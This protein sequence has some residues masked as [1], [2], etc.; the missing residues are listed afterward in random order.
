MCRALEGEMKGWRRPPSCPP[1]RPLPSPPPLPV[2]LLS[3]RLSPP[4]PPSHWSALWGPER[5]PRLSLRAGA[6]RARAP[7]SPAPLLPP[8]PCAP[9]RP[10]PFAERHGLRASP[11]LEQ[12]LLSVLFLKRAAAPGSDPRRDRGLASASR[13]CGP[14]LHGSGRVLLDLGRGV[15]GDESPASGR[16]RLPGNGGRSASP[17]PGSRSAPGSPARRPEAPG[18]DRA[19]PPRAGPASRVALH[20]PPAPA[21]LSLILPVLGKAACLLVR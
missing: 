13:G 4:S 20:P 12:A 1:L 9:G 6:A 21:L 5:W 8:G 7:A 2:P 14:A 19:H 18:G 17:P 3:S 15:G 11:F 16:L 10:G